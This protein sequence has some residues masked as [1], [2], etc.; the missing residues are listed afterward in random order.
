MVD[1]KVALVTGGSRGIGRAICLELARSGFA[2]GVNYNENLGAAE[3]TKQMLE[4][5]G[6]PVELCQGD[7]SAKSHRD[8]MVSLIMERFGRIDMLVNN[9]GAAPAVRKD[10]LETDEEVFDHI[11]NTNL[12][13]PY[14]LT[15]RVANEMIQLTQQGAIDRGA[16]INISSL[17]RYAAA[18]NYGEYCISK[19]GV[20]MITTLFAVRLAEHGINVYEISPGIIETDMTSAPNVRDAYNAKLADGLAPINRWGKAEEVALAVSAIAKGH[21]PF[22]TGS[23]FDVDGGFHLR[24]L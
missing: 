23:I 8:L 18:K 4:E 5:I 9:A 13:A 12:K 2:V 17:R 16:I 3:Q 14:F 7:V 6:V 11:L 19:A 20:S 10:I 24:E 15:Q 22:S 1:Q 21:F